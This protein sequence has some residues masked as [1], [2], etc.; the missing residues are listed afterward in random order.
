MSEEKNKY[1]VQIGHPLTEDNKVDMRII[2][3]RITTIGGMDEKKFIP[4][5]K[6]LLDDHFAGK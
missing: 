4:K 3:I 5:L 1:T 2:E 6:E